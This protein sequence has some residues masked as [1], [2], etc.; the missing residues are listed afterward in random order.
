MAIFPVDLR[1]SVSSISL[2][3]T[4][5]GRYRLLTRVVPGSGQLPPANL[6][7]ASVSPSFAT[8]SKPRGTQGS[9]FSCDKVK[10]FGVNSYGFF[11]CASLV[12]AKI[13]ACTEERE[14]LCN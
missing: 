13:K 5:S 12:D 6:T 7:I 9:A 1:I 2:F 11:A 8:V 10:F 3:G 4:K 14:A